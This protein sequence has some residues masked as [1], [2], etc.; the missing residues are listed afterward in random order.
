MTN[1]GMQ[2]PCR[3]VIVWLDHHTRL[4]RLPCNHSKFIFN[5]ASAF[6]I[7]ILLTWP[8]G[9]SRSE[10]GE[11]TP[12]QN[13]PFRL[14]DVDPHLIQQCLGP[15]HAPPQTAA[16]TVE[17]LSHTD[18]VKSPLVTMVRSKF[19]PKST[20]FGGPIAKPQYLPHPWTRP[21]YGAKRLPD[22]ICRFSTMQFCWLDWWNR[23]LKHWGCWCILNKLQTIEAV[24]CV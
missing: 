9:I 16:P 23:R 22:T 8:N 13:F 11:Q 2:S 4:L 5:A 24:F 19:A 1:A 17:A 7:K 18:A 21:T 10:N 15:Q 20:P 12:P 3:L 6:C 14:H